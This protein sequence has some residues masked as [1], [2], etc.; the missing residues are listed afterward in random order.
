MNMSNN[1]VHFISL[2][3][4]G[5]R[6]KAKRDTLNTW[7]KKQKID[8][9]FLQETY[10][11]E[12]LENILKSE[13]NMD[14][15]SSF[16][17]THSRGVSILYDRRL[18]MEVENQIVAKDGRKILMNLKI[19]DTP[20]TIINL[21][22]PTN[23][24][25]RNLFF[26]KTLFWMKRNARH[27]IIIGGDLNCV[28]NKSKDTKNIK[29]KNVE[30]KS[31]QKIIRKFKLT[32][33]WRK[34]WPNKMQFTWR[35][36]SLNL[37]SRLDYWLIQD[38]L[39]QSTES[40][41]IRPSI[42]TDHNAISLKLKIGKLNKGPGYWKFNSSLINDETYKI[43]LKQII[44]NF[45]NSFNNTNVSKQIKWEM[46]KRK[47]K[48]YTIEYC[49]Q[50]S[51][52]KN[53]VV[54]TLEKEVEKLEKNAFNNHQN[55]NQSYIDA[56]NKL[57]KMYSQITKGAIIRSRVK[58]FEE[59]ETNSKYFMGL[60]KSKNVKNSIIELKSKSGKR[61]TNTDDILNET[62]DYY[63]RLYKSKDINEDQM[64]HYVN[65][66]SIK[67]LKDGDILS[68][69]GPMT[70]D[71]CTNVVNCLKTNRSPGCDGLT[72]EFYKSF[73]GDV[74]DLVIDSLNEGYAQGELS[75]SQKRGVIKLLHKKGEKTNLDNYRPIS[76]LNY[77]YKICTA[78]L[79]RRVQKI[80]KN[81]IS[82]DQC[83]YIK[84][85]FIGRNIRII[86]DVINYCEL[87]EN[88]AAILFIDFKKAFDS[89][90]ISFLNKCLEKFGFGE[91]FLNWVKT[92]YKNIDSCIS[93]NNWLSKSFKM[94]SG[95]RQGCPLSALLFILAVEFM[96]SN[97][98]QN[99]QINGFKF[100]NN[101][102]LEIKT[103]Q[104]ADDTTL[105]VNNKSSVQNVLN[106]IEKFSTVSGITLNKSKTEGIYL[107]NSNITDLNPNIKWTNSPVKSLGIYFGKCKKEVEN[108]NWNPKVNKLQN[109][110]NRWK[111]RKLTF[112][113]KV[114]IIKTLGISQILYNAACIK[115]PDSIIKKVDKI[116][117]NF[118]WD[119]SKEKVKRNTTTK[120]MIYGGLNMVNTEAKINVFQIKWIQR[121]LNG[122]DD[123]VWNKFVRKLFEPFGGLNF[124]LELHCKETD[125]NNIFQ[126]KI[127]DFY[128]DII[129]VW[130]KL[131]DKI[132]SDTDVTENEIIWANKHV[133][134]KGNILYYSKWIKAGITHLKDIVKGNRFINL[135]EL[136]KK[137]K[138]VSNI[139]ELHKL[140][141]AIPRNWKD[142]VN[143]G[144]LSAIN[145]QS[146]TILSINKKRKHICEI[147]SKILYKL[148]NVQD[149]N[150]S[151]IKYW[152][153]ENI[154]IDNWEYIFRFKIKERFLNKIG[155]FQ[156]SML[157]NMI[158][159]KKNLFTWTLC[160]SNLC[161]FCN[162]VDDYEHFFITCKQN[163]DLWGKFSNYVKTVRNENFDI[164][165]KHIIGGW[166]IENK[167]YY[168]INILIEIASF[169]I[170]KSKMIYN[171]TNKA[172]PNTLLFIQDIKK[173]DQILSASKMKT[174]LKVNNE[175]L[176]SCKI[177]WNII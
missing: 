78:V 168:I 92:I 129:K 140:I 164:A 135:V 7:I 136:S 128:V 81:I 24:I 57:E 94:E 25:D 134:H 51:K 98:K 119:S 26:K 64:N 138:C 68:C 9:C 85:R 38:D 54:K 59:G 77:D 156:F 41:D 132:R 40:T 110:L 67:Q 104:M 120:E 46:C 44:Q 175:D 171:Q 37:Y 82:N 109:T 118:L 162:V 53:D 139:F 76:L 18:K 87:N 150:A 113:G 148:F 17:S 117:Y 144:N 147:D 174:Y 49:K 52:T 125:V 166:N 30:C 116:I 55:L 56:K 43:K 35:Q 103:I 170:Y 27:R 70:T 23:Y 157:Y 106:E 95:I 21:Y 160:D 89:L 143:N 29:N 62:V 72:P 133:R 122:N 151:C 61:L 112:Y 5:L 158:C 154:Y 105:F 141:K 96:S 74:K 126:G 86:E 47:I 107:G 169:T 28:Q 20:F 3:V 146:S 4:R 165:L 34:F 97:V 1:C 50:K 31:L 8:I 42:K 13:W 159:C 66:T 111:T 149:A 65:N 12:T 6:A 173:L 123:C 93:I 121:L 60:E 45:K 48:D 16:G 115:V 71:E 69:E 58:W 176:N 84:G 127:P 100:L 63:T 114:T 19:N 32:D 161:S 75:Y 137:V 79:A 172:I 130:F 2:N 88:D 101:L 22:A 102:E 155:H 131:Q 90:N 167:E 142:K 11:D 80:I 152:E 153:K 36:I 83:G 177:F 145:R 33:I 10:L 91:Q 124:I 39:T 15:L 14:C 73:W 163:K 108:L 99:K